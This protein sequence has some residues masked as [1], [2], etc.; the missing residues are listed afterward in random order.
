MIADTPCPDDTA[1]RPLMLGLSDMA[2][3]PGIEA[4]FTS[5]PRCALR[6]AA[7]FETDDHLVSA[8]QSAGV[9]PVAEV[10]AGVLDRLRQLHPD[11]VVGNM[12]QRISELGRIDWRENSGVVRWELSTLAGMTG[13]TAKPLHEKDSRR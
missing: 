5:C 2:A 1:L 9:S 12:A 13:S 7:T 8:I 4:H 10:P 11:L 6:A 3:D